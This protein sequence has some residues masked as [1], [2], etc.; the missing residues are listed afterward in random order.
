M[1]VSF[2][3]KLL[4]GDKISDL[5]IWQLSSHGKNFLLGVMFTTVYKQRTKS[6]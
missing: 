2:M 4:L 1:F 5:V 6:W 3:I